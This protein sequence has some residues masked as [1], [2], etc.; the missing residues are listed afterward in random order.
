MPPPPP[1]PDIGIP[2]EHRFVEAN[3]VRFHVPCAGRGPLVLLL[4]GFPQFWYCWRHQ[5]P[6]LA[7]RFT[8]AA[9][10]L[11][12]YNET[13]K[14]RG[15][16]DVPTLTQDVVA[17]IRALGHERAFV[18]GHDWGG[19]L[20]WSTAM[21]HPEVVERLV[22]LNCPHPVLMAQRVWR[23]PQIF[24]SAYIF[25]FQFPWLPELLIRARNYRSL[26]VGMRGWTFRKGAFSDA[27]LALYRAALDQP[28]AL[29][30]ALNYYRALRGYPPR[31]LKQEARVIERP[32]RVIWAAN[33]YALGNELLVGL[34]RWVPGVEVEMIHHCSHWVQEEQPEHV[35]M[36]VDEFLR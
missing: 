33:D 28:R 17:L 12:G 22:V 27:D 4:H 21:H 6:F 24:R 18:V 30:C 23:P 25:L 34:D 20:A 9:P 8:V 29:T 7:E 36:L 13:E 5:L 19:G 32:T 2:V 11:R 26:E 35:N 15:G 10:D 16:Y 3:G 31:R 14:P 1:R